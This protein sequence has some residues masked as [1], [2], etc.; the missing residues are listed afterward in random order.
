MKTV[1][2][3]PPYSRKLFQMVWEFTTIVFYYAPFEIL[4]GGGRISIRGSGHAGLAQEISV[5]GKLES[6]G[7]TVSS[8]GFRVVEKA[9]VNSPP[10]IAPGSMPLGAVTDRQSPHRP[11]KAAESTTRHTCSGSHSWWLHT[12]PGNAASRAARQLSC[13]PPAGKQMKL[14]CQVQPRRL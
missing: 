5:M 2:V 13:L 7:R 3:P 6:P 11:G 8:S 14:E 10:G 12:W 1:P 4:F 9:R